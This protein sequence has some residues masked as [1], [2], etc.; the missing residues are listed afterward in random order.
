MLRFTREF[1]EFMCRESVA[2]GNRHMPVGN[3]MDN[4]E[5]QRRKTQSLEIQNKL[6]YYEFTDEYSH[7]ICLSKREAECLYYTLK[8]RTAMEIGD[9]LMI[10]P[11][12]VESYIAA[13]KNKLGCDTRAELFDKAYALGIS[14][15]F[16][17]K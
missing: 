1:S 2:P 7:K 10:S 15:L 3:F 11:K 13:A 8:G 12:T 9:I 16:N 14:T 5:E 17:P 4:Q 6:K